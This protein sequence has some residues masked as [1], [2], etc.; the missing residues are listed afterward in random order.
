[1]TLALGLFA[2]C[3]ALALLHVVLVEKQ[4][5]LDDLIDGNRQRRERVDKLQ[6]EI[7]ELDSPEGLVEQ[8]RAA[9]LVPAAELVVLVPVES[10]LLPPPAEDPFGLGAPEWAPGE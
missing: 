10:S 2:V 3:L 8:A 9:G 4:A 1:M 5:Q 7:A 6:A